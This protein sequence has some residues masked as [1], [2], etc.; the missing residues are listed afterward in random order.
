MAQLDRWLDTFDEAHLSA[1]G[2]RKVANVVA[3]ALAELGVGNGEPASTPD[4]PDDH[5][6][7]PQPT[8]T[9]DGTTVTVTWPAVTYASSINLWARDRA[10]GATGL[11]RFVT[12]TSTTVTGLAGHSYD[13]WLAPVQGYLPIGT[14]SNT[15]RV[16]VPSAQPTAT[17]T[18]SPSPTPTPSP[19][20]S[21]TPTPTPTPT[22]DPSPTP[23]PE[24]TAEPESTEDPTPPAGSLPSPG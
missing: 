8:A 3:R 16:D 13:M 14:T 20:P 19:S 4:P 9:V 1:S 7:S 2:Q 24:P 5:T 11:K 17:P 23:T 15:I 18:P 22:A 6:W 21:P 10:S 12:G